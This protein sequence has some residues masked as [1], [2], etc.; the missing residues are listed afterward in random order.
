MF[1]FAYDITQGN[2]NV[3]LVK[4]TDP[5]GNATEPGL[6]L[7]PPDDPKFNW[8]TQ[9]LTDRLAGTPTSFA[10][11]DPDGAAGQRTSTPRSPTR[12]TTPPRT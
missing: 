1:Q 6:L 12:R 2:K 11:T 3:K 9:T 10:Y 4:V 7:T 5:R 8:S